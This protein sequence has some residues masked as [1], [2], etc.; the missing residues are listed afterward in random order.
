MV[1]DSCREY[2]DITESTQKKQ[3][4]IQ[5]TVTEYFAKMRKNAH[6]DFFSQNKFLTLRG[7]ADFF[8]CIFAKICAFF[9][10]KSSF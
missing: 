7:A 2:L 9:R 4:L 6:Y 1:Y 3:K 10:E 8:K 5:V